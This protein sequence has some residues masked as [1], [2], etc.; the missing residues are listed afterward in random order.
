[1]VLSLARMDGARVL[2]VGTDQPLGPSKGSPE[3]AAGEELADDGWLVC[4]ANM[5]AAAAD[6]ALRDLRT[7]AA[8]AGVTEPE[9]MRTA[10]WPVPL[11]RNTYM[12]NGPADEEFSQARIA[13]GVP[14]HPIFADA[15]DE[16]G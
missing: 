14:L 8:M 3:C 12:L 9:A 5:T 4:T 16:D 7:W 10:D 2:V 6:A 15:P 13:A 11:L 1:M